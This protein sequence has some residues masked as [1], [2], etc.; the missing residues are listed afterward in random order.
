MSRQISLVVVVLMYLS[1]CGG[2]GG[3][4]SDADVTPQPDVQAD[5]VPDTSTLEGVYDVLDAKPQEIQIEP[6]VIVQPETGEQKEIIV[7]PEVTGGGG[8]CIDIVTCLAEN[9][10]QTQECLNKCKSEGSPEAQG[11]FDGLMN[12][13]QT[14]CIQYQNKQGLLAYCTFTECE[15]FNKPCT[16]NGTK[17]CSELFT[18]GQGC[19][20]NQ[21]CIQ[22]CFDQTSYEA[23]I[24]FWQIAKCIE[25]KC[26]G[27]AQDQVCLQTQCMND[28]MACVQS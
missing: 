28:L 22:E 8:T 21:A 19:G 15:Q 3:G 11:Q 13:I 2:G 18:C 6:E 23:K 10:C 17:K 1:A 12:C 9:K 25:E 5:N 14:K 27:N 26:N 16:K 24:K 20:Q 4:E 7:Q